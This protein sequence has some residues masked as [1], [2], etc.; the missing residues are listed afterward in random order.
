MIDPDKPRF[1]PGC[2]GGA[3]T[4]NPAGMECKSCAFAADCSVISVAR[5]NRLRAE[6]GLAVD[7]PKTVKKPAASAPV[8]SASPTMTASLPKKV[9]DLLGR[10]ERSG[11]KVAETLAK[12]E[13]PFP[14]IGFL[15]LTAHVLLK[16]PEGV[17]RQMLRTCLEHKFG[18]GEASAAPHATQAFQVLI[19]L[20]VATETNGRLVLKK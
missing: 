17:D 7:K 13:N 16:R 18:W 6:L 19:A 8:S 20:G 15:K 1:A 14:T 9:Q 12:G 4:Y 2:F 5:T 11:V 3:L 10:I